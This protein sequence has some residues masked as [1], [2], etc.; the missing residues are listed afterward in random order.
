[1]GTLALAADPRA[2]GGGMKGWSP[3]PQP[4][5]GSS[6]FESEI[7]GYA[8]LANAGVDVKNVS[9]EMVPAV[10]VIYDFFNSMDLPMPA[11]TSGWRAKH[12]IS[13]KTEKGRPHGEGLG[14]DF[15]MP[16]ELVKNPKA[17]EVLMRTLQGMGYGFDDRPHGTSKG[18]RDPDHIHIHWRGKP[19][20][21]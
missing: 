17:R 3:F 5:R 7:S 13:G 20:G 10:R 16:K 19:I 9:P 11:I 18:K 15:R 14:L 8:K 2:E 1:M 6:D 4:L 12:P 21:G